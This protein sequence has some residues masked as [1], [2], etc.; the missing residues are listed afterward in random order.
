MKPLL[1]IGIILILDVTGLTLGRVSLMW[2]NKIVG[3]R[4]II[5]FYSIIAIAFVHFP[6]L[7]IQLTSQLTTDQRYRLELTVWFVPSIIGNAVAVRPSS[8]PPRYTIYRLHPLSL[9]IDNWPR[10]RSNVPTP[11]LAH[12][13]NPTPMAPHWLCRPSNG[14][15]DGWLCRTSLCYWFAS[16]KIWDWVLAAIVSRIDVSH[17]IFGTNRSFYFISFSTQDGIHDVRDAS[18]VGVC[19]RSTQESGLEEISSFF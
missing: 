7:R 10:P 8:C 16:V 17:S 12:D 1:F 13:P 2:L 5:F 9:G 14:N 3:E 19:P 18:C 15:W 11:R 6:G 4:R